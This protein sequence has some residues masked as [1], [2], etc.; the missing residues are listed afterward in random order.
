MEL[1]QLEH[2]V[3]VVEEGSLGTAAIRLNQT[4]SSISGSIRSLDRELRAELFVAGSNGTELTDAG[5]A[6]LE[7]ARATLACAQRARSDVAASDGVLR[8]CIRIATVAVPRTIDVMATVHRLQHDHP[9]VDVQVVQTG[10]RRVLQLVT[11]GQVDL[12]IA[13]VAARARSSVRFEPLISAPLAL[14]CPV[15]HALAGAPFA[16]PA[17][18][19]DEA[20][21]DLPRGWWARDTFD[22]MFAA[23]DLFRRSRLEV[24]DPLAVLRAVRDSSILGYGLAA[25]VDGGAFP[26]IASTRLVGAPSCEIGLVTRRGAR[27]SQPVAAFLDAYRDR[28]GRAG[29]GDDPALAPSVGAVPLLSIA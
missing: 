27:R 4:A 24:D 16:D 28:C 18:L 22:R 2:F 3:A 5:W 10:A 19:V 13:P 23:R 15:G 8:G 6:L 17:E 11:D 21:V 25:E 29:L 14:I 1:R 12:G 20:I 7:P 9:D 26:D